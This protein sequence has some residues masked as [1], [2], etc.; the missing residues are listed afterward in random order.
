M[1]YLTLSN[2][3]I[4][5]QSLTLVDEGFIT[6]LQTTLNQVTD[7]GAVTA[8]EQATDP[9]AQYAT[10]SDLAS[11]TS[12]SAIHV[13]AGGISNNQIAAGAAIDWS[14]INK[15]GAAASDVG[16]ATSSHTHA[17]LSA[18]G[19]TPPVNPAVGDRWLETSGNL[20]RYG[21]SWEWTGAYW[22]S[23]EFR[24]Y[25]FSALS[26]TSILRFAVDQLLNIVP[27]FM[28][29]EAFVSSANDSSNYWI[30][31]VE[32]RNATETQTVISLSTIDNRTTPN[33]QMLTGRFALGDAIAV[34]ATGTKNICFRAGKNLNPGT[35]T[36]SI[37]FGFYLARP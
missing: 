9:H 1:D 19:S 33:G 26:A 6:D 10:D 14:K 31:Q 16:A 21:W 13:P 22:R 12:N 20:T 27:S 37:V 7:T 2:G 23:P 28:E 34:A 17:G 36:V 29:F 18:T 32:Q 30:F 3:Q 8:H 4:Q 5:R 11:H 25:A 24:T 15:S 35:L